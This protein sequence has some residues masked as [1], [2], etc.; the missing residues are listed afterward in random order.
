MTK[1]L[2]ILSRIVSYPQLLLD[3]I[4]SIHEFLRKPLYPQ[5][6]SNISYQALSD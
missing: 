5:A 1:K 2:V 4:Q 6:Y 3:S